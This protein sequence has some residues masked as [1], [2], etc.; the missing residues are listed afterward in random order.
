MQL[1]NATEPLFVDWKRA[2]CKVLHN[3]SPLHMQVRGFALILRLGLAPTSLSSVRLTVRGTSR[4]LLLQH[5]NPWIDL[6]W[7]RK[8]FR[9]ERVEA[10]F[11]GYE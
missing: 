1:M 8:N 7:R 3:K 6:F 4:K 9:K 5:F 11:R 10:E 2:L